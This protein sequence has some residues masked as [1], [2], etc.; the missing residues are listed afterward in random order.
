MRSI[1][2]PQRA[3]LTV[4][5]R[6]LGS[7]PSSGALK[8]KRLREIATSFSLYFHPCFGAGFTVYE[9]L[10][11]EWRKDWIAKCRRFWSSD[12][13]YP[14]KNH[15][16]FRRWL[17]YFLNRSECVPVSIN[18][19]SSSKSFCFQINNQSGWRWHSQQPIYFPFNLWGLYESG[20]DPF[21]CKRVTALAKTETSSPLLT[22]SF[23][24]FL[25]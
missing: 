18:I 11:M 12:L 16:R 17:C 9:P 1:W 13:A 19:N 22:H 10:K 2:R 7:S 23:K 4:N 5:Q 14:I 15:L 20:N 24:D 3:K 25:N 8:I 6:I 21:S